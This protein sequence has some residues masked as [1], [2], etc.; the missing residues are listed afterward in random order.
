MLENILGLG[1]M[2]ENKTFFCFFF[3]LLKREINLKVL[4]F[5]KKI[6]FRNISEKAEYFNTGFVFY[7]VKIQPNI[8]QNW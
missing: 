7:S 5:L 1:C 4:R 8:K 6:V 2:H 3:F